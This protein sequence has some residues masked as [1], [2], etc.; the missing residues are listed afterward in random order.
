MAAAPSG[1]D[2]VVV[3]EGEHGLG[4]GVV[5]TVITAGDGAS[6]W[7]LLGEGVS[8]AGMTLAFMKGVGVAGTDVGAAGG[9][10]G[11]AGGAEAEEVRGAGASEVG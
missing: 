6:C 4:E 5:V 10:V 2:D 3:H 7:V 9:D 8:E 1:L 11:G